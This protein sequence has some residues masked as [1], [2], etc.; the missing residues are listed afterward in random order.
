MVVMQKNG[1]KVVLIGM[2]HEGGKISGMLAEDHEARAAGMIEPTGETILD[3]VSDTMVE[4]YRPTNGWEIAGDGM[5]ENILN[6]KRYRYVN[7]D[8]PIY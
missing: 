7:H 5:N 8:M 4:R 1:T 3:E 2:W 6:I